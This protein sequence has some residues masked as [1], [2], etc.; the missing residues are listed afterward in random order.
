M[1]VPKANEDIH[2]YN[3]WR[4]S[5]VLLEN[6]TIVKWQYDTFRGA[7]SSNDI[8]ANQHFL[9]TGTQDSIGTKDKHPASRCYVMRSCSSTGKPFKRAEYP[10]IETMARWIEEKKF[11]VVGRVKV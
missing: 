4:D 7:T 8:K 5:I 1:V 3:R 11:V 10:Y 2:A 6:G 9:I